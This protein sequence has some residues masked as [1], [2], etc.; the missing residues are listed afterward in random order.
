MTRRTFSVVHP[1][2]GYD[3]AKFADKHGE[4]IWERM[5]ASSFSHS[6]PEEKDGSDRAL[7]IPSHSELERVR[8]ER[9]SRFRFVAKTDVS[10]FYHSIYTHSVPWA[11][12]GKS[13]AKADRDPKSKNLPFNRLDQILRCGQ[14]GQ[15]IGIPVGPDVSRLVAEGVF[16][17]IDSEFKAR[18]KVTDCDVIRH[19]DDI[20]IGA[21]SHA[22]AEEALWRYREAIRSFELD[23]NETKTQI[24]AEDF[25]FV[26]SWPTDVSE[27]ID[28][29][30]NSDKRVEERLRT[31]LEYAF[32]LTA[33]ANDDG[34]AKFV[35]RYLD[36][37]GCMG[38]YWDTIEPY[39]KRSAV[40]FGHSVDYVSRIVVWKKLAG[41]GLDEA[42][43][44][45]ILKSVLSRHGRLGN[46]SEVCWAL[47]ACEKLSVTVPNE[48]AAEI[49]E[50][51]GALAITAVLNLADMGLT[52]H[53]A[54]DIARKV[55]SSEDAN[56]TYWPVLLEWH[57]RKWE[58][59]KALRLGNSTIEGMAREGVTIFARASVPKVLQG[60]DLAKY[61]SIL[62]AIEHRVSAYDDD[63]IEFDEVFD[64][65]GGEAGGLVD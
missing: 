44:G 1:V 26:D 6:V 28:F 23:I 21:N 62:Q 34:V 63:E 11:F 58:G 54:F 59:S 55:L 53:E 57:S 22:D 56:G 15:T 52:G 30:L 33:S 65:E 37:A 7:D 49:I 18:C 32:Y 17:A 31:A 29:A 24:Y 47:Y 36:Q 51:C 27:K 35:I 19:V 43:W 38:E 25:R 60:I 41:G 48:T 13:E 14:D 39:L 64:D 9:L 5:R 2:T 16:A 42:E 61:D 45:I 50:N 40:H 20:W 10:R 4:Y 12:H 3:L 46:D 8:L